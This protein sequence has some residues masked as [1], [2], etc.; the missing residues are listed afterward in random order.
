MREIIL[1]LSIQN[2]LYRHAKVL[3]RD[4]IRRSSEQRFVELAVVVGGQC[5]IFAQCI[6][7]REGDL[8]CTVTTRRLRQGGHYITIKTRLIAEGQVET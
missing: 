3:C 1:R 5:E 4:G 6:V 8:Q 7:C 2:K